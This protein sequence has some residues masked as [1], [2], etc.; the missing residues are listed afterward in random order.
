M[1]GTRMGTPLVS[2][3]IATF[4]RTDCLLETLAGLNSQ[5][6]S[7]FEVIIVEDGSDRD[8][9]P[10]V[11]SLG[12]LYPV[13]YRRIAKKGRAGARNEGIRLAHGEIL[14]F[15]DDHSRP[16]STLIAE[17]VKHHLAGELH[18]G[19]RGRVEYRN[20]IRR[21]AEWRREGL[22]SR[23]VHRL[24]GNSPIVNF[25]THNLSVKRAVIERVGGFD[26][27][28]TL[29]GAEDQELGIRIRKG[30]FRLGYISDA[31]AYNIRL[32]R[33][34]QAA[35]ERAVESGRMAALLA[36]KHPEY[37]RA[38][39]LHG[40]NR[41]IHLNRRSMRLVSGFIEKDDEAASSPPARTTA[42][43]LLKTTL[44]ATPP[45]RWARIRKT[46]YFYS[47]Y[48]SSER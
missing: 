24:Q 23:F 37:R 13:S 18:G 48:E 9:G 4:N 8:A 7:P 26:E 25:G 15:F 30:G 29:Y 10:M 44:P 47:A 19:F 36:K 32:P 28:F 2:V 39:G 35:A 22:C 45:P 21:D 14:L 6:Y 38:L 42:S 20:G 11:R 34:W 16:C 46:L 43:F 17:H 5:T 33:S 41:L 3:I 1:D 31:L 27:D 12:L 40:L